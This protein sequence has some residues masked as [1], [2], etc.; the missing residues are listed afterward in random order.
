[1]VKGLKVRH[2]ALR[3]A[4]TFLGAS[5]LAVGFASPAFAS[6]PSGGNTAAK[7]YLIIQGGSNTTYLMMQALSS[8]F[9]Q[10]PGCDL[11]TASGTQPLDYGCP[12][13]NGE[14]GVTKS[15]GTSADGENGFLPFA[16]ENPF[17]DVLVQ[18]PAI[19]SSNGIAELETQGAHGTATFSGVTV[20]GTT[21]VTINSGTFAGVQVK[22]LITDTGGFI[23]PGDT[24]T[25]VSP[26]ANAPT[27]LTLATAA[28]G[29]ST[30]DS[31]TTTAPQ[32]SAPLDAARSSRAPNLTGTTAGD[33]KGLNF[34]AYAM[35]GV[36][37]LHWTSA[38]PNGSANTATPTTTPS[39]AV[40]NLTVA[41]LTNI[42]L[43]NENCTVGT[44]SY[45]ENWICVQPN[46]V[47][48]VVG[49]QF[50]NDCLPTPLPSCYENAPISVY[51]AQNGSG[52]EGTWATLLNLSAN[53]N[54][55]PFETPPE[56][57]AHIIFEN[58][59]ESI[60]QNKDEA[61]AIFFFSYGKF[62]QVC[63]GTTSNPANGALGYCGTA[64]TGVTNGTSVGN[65]ALGEINGIAATQATISTQ[66][67]G[68][69]T[70]VSH[71]G[72]TFSAA[73]TTVK[74][75]N[76]SFITSSLNGDTVTD[77]TTPGNIASGTAQ[78]KVITSPTLKMKL[79]QAAAGSSALAGDT[80]QFCT[81]IFPGDRL[82]YNVYSD[83]SNPDI[84]AS[85]TASLNAISEDGWLCKA[86]TNSDIDPNTG[87]SYLSEIQSTITS[88]GFFPLATP[89]HPIV[90]DGNGSTVA[91]Y[92][93]TA[94][95]ITNPAWTELS[96][97]KY[98]GSVEAGSP[99]NFP[100]PNQDTDGFGTAGVDG[101]PSTAT[102]S[103]TNPYG[104]CL[105][106]TTDG[107]STN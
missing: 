10:A 86:S 7:N 48:A 99:W 39:G 104:Y 15:N 49:G 81:S 107:N 36:S 55:F 106:L 72:Y 54:V 9:N 21:T 91:P 57:S 94:S 63:G 31:V 17:N 56:N 77:L 65:L 45:T 100:T 22:D 43:G 89:G 2:R 102:P 18:E 80:L 84:A 50:Q 16:Q 96:G 30:T 88:Q 95:G 37:W 75:A 12:G 3:A 83:G 53:S 28:T 35:D 1:M 20:N 62:T 97:S 40:T 101:V 68:A 60:F 92:T 27:S 26:S 70:C 4:V 90:E 66:L 47:T 24:V 46:S 73:S 34:V 11:A 61:N 71:P 33:N 78:K 19:G 25:A 74:N 23:P 79:S 52:T 67:P 76:S 38:P 51:M 85:S 41:Q 42:Y 5:A 6:Q 13:L 59:T 103:A 87:S 8:V 64:P 32:N 82:L 44:Q 29:S 105:V 69:V 93:T 14:Q 98:Q 58:E